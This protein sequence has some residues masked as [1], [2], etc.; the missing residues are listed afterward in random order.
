MDYKISIILPI[1]NV[2]PFLRAALDSIVNQTFNLNEL[3]VLMVDDCST[4]GS[5]E[6]IDEYS[7]K[8][9]NFIAIHLDEN[10]GTA[11]KPRNR[12]LDYAHGDYI[13]FLDSD[14]E[15]MEDVCEVLYNKL[16]ETDADIVT[17]NAICIQPNKEILDINYSK[18]YYEFNPDKNLK[19]FKPFRIWGTL[20]KKSLINDNNIRCIRAATN[21]D[22]HFVYNCYLH[23]DKIVYI[24]DYIGVKYY[25]RGADEFESLTHKMS[26]FN[27]IST[28]DAFIQLLGL[29]NSVNVTEDFVEDPF[30]KL[31][32]SRFA[33]KWDMSSND[34][35]EVFDKI[36]EYLTKSRYAPVLPIHHKILHFFVK[37]N[38]NNSLI[39]FQRGYSYLLSTKF[40]KKFLLSKIKHNV[41]E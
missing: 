30:I 25:E 31:I 8:Y 10:S 23:A 28:Y 4:D 27:I 16:L 17:G 40:S 3:E 9:E 29:I 1:F 41:V 36:R 18:K 15:F 21:D 39:L 11:G 20:Y 34:K 26:K 14:D 5:G 24:N 12:G 2:K 38:L 7:D 13:M 22:T 19:I 32:Y 37:H 35:K 6:I 33:N